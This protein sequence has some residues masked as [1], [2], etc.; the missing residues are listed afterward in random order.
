MLAWNGKMIT[1]FFWKDRQKKKEK[2]KREQILEQMHEDLLNDIR[3]NFPINTLFPSITAS[4]G[5][6]FYTMI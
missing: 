3:K 6:S 4:K 1:F 5:R 2:M